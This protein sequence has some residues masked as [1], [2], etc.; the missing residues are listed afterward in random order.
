MFRYIGDYYV[1]ASKK[2]AFYYAALT[3]LETFA[4]TK[5]F[6]F[7]NIF[8]KFPGVHYE[9]LSVS[10]ARYTSDIRTPAGLKREQTLKKLN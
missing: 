8:K 6:M 7:K 3:R 5:E 4:L 10:F 9:L 2:S 1:L